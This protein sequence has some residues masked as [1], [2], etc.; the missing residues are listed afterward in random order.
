MKRLLEDRLEPISRDKVSLVRLDGMTSQRAARLAE[1][2][3]HSVLD[4]AAADPIVLIIDTPFTAP[5]VF[6][7]IDQA[8]LHMLLGSPDPTSETS[9]LP[10]LRAHGIRT[11]T[12]LHRVYR[13]EVTDDEGSFF[14][15][16]LRRQIADA[17]DALEENPNFR[18][19]HRWRLQTV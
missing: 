10:L 13:G 4:M 17:I 7:W 8:I 14:D 3:S 9:V 15:N 5:L 12:D 11:A 1:E 18:R 16:I 19:V 2:D 6:D